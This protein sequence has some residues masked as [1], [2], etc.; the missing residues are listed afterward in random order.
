MRLLEAVYNGAT[1]RVIT[2]CGVGRVPMH[3]EFTPGV[4]TGHLPACG[5]VRC[6]TRKCQERIVG[7]SV[8]RWPGAIGKY[9]GWKLT[10]TN[11]DKSEEDHNHS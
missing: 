3:N 6:A 11:I 5:M 4:S 9:K 7:A 8:L 1:V 2:D 10:P